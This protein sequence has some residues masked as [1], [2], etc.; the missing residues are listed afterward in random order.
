MKA[1]VQAV[2]GLADTG[3]EDTLLQGW[4][5]DGVI[6]V[7]LRTQCYVTDAT[8]TETS[9]TGTTPSTRGSWS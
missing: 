3:T 2:I 4:L 8:M 5:N 7:L 1:E 6:D 9:G